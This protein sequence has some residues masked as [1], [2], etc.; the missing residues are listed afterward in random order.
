MVSKPSVGL[1]ALLLPVFAVF[2]QGE[3]T[4]KTVVTA[5]RLTFEYKK[6]MAVF[7][8]HVVVVDPRIRIESD[9]LRLVFSK[10]NEIKSV[11]AT[12]NV[13]LRSEDKTGA[14]NKA[15]YVGETEEVTLTG[16]ARLNRGGRDSVTG[17]RIIFY[18][19]EDRVVVEGGTQLV[20]FPEDGPVKTP[21]KR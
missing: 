16:N 12:G 21:L 17:D 3:G 18:L 11:T 7:D 8:G 13:R 4:N 19:D 14:C 6:Q 20:I 2:A 10:T 9:E 1:L 15:V 5:D